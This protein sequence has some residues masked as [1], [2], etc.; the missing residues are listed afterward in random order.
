MRARRRM[1]YSAVIRGDD[2]RPMTST[3]FGHRAGRRRGAPFAPLVV[4]TAL[5]LG[6]VGFIAYV[7]WPRWPGPPVAADAPPLPITVAGVAFKVAPA[8]MR[9]PVQRRPGEHERVDLAYL[10]PSLEPASASAAPPAGAPPTAA[11]S[12]E[13]VFVT[14]AAAE[15]MLTPAERVRT[16]YPRYIAAHPTDGP[17]GLALRAFR[18]G[19]P[20]QGEDLIYSTDEPDRFVLRCTRNGAGPL[21]GMC[22]YERRI[23]QADLVVRFPR[24]WLNDWRLVAGNIDRLLKMLRPG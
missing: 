24:D 1:R 9:M 20:Y 6:A 7:L 13:R 5:I 21:L 12:I 19:T 18:D 3:N 10:W 2:V 22:L 15:G 11:R 4:F 16:I 23:E 17:N 8:A 14:I